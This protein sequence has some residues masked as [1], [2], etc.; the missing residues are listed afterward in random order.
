MACDKLRDKEAMHR[1]NMDMARVVMKDINR[2]KK[3]APGSL[4]R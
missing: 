3:K 4:L 2:K 1:N